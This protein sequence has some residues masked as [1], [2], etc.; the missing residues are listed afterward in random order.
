V[1]AVHVDESGADAKAGLSW[2]F[3]FA[4]DQKIDGNA[5]EPLSQRARAIIQADVDRLYTEV[6][7]LVAINRRLTTA[8]VR[9]TD[10]AVYRGE[11]AVRAGLADRVGTLDAAIAEMA[12][13]LDQASMPPAA[14]SFPPITRGPC[15]W[16]RTRPNAMNTM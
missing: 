11:L 5:H 3:V 9:S 13:E 1:V 12:A 2:S 7:G 10:A 4:G 14:P 16:R 8:A 15:P 6:C